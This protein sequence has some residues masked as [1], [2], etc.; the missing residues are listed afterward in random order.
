[1][2]KSTKLEKTGMQKKKSYM[3][4]NNILS[5]G[6]LGN[7]I[8]NILPKSLFKKD[9]KKIQKK[10]DTIEKGIEKRTKEIKK[11]DVDAK[12]RTDGMIKKLEKQFGVKFSKKEI[13]DLLKKYKR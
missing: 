8:K 9:P 1:M 5:E 4:L 10:I 2:S 11:L 7:L 3:N 12:K 6:M 13:E